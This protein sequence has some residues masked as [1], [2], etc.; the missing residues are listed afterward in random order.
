MQPSGV[1]LN[2]R[3]SF[4]KPIESGDYV[5]AYLIYGSKYYSTSPTV[6]CFQLVY[7]FMYSHLEISH[8]K[9]LTNY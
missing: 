2:F 6:K 3:V 4:S 5:T 9:R 1:L 8:F 7:K